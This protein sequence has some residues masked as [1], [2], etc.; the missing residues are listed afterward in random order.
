MTCLRQVYS[1][2]SSHGQRIFVIYFLYSQCYAN[3]LSNHYIRRQKL[4]RQS[5]KLIKCQGL[6]FLMCKHC[7]YSIVIHMEK[8]QVTE[9]KGG[10]LVLQ[11]TDSNSTKNTLNTKT[12]N[13][14]RKKWSIPMYNGPKQEYRITSCDSTKNI[15][16]IGIK[17][18]LSYKNRIKKLNYKG[19]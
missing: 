7:L 16:T 13:N 14:L 4:S 10:G 17:K 18:H 8:S 12:S 11:L 2:H 15:C 3:V 19:L 1:T 6:V 5:S 9:W